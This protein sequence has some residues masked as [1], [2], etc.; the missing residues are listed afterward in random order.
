MS[1]FVLLRPWWLAILPPLALAAI[2]LARRGG[3]AGGWE[4]VIPG[5]TIAALRALGHLGGGRTAW[6]TLAPLLAAGVLAA[7]LAGPALPRRDAPVL[8]QSDA[9]VIAVDMSPSV[10]RGPG[11]ADAQAAAASVLAASAGRP[12]GLVLYDG[13]AYRASAPTEDRRSLETQIAVLGPETM[14]SAGS[15]PSAALGLAREMLAGVERADVVL[16]SD[17]GG[18]DEAATSEAGRLAGA[19]VTLSVLVLDGEAAGAPR[20]DA[21]ALR[22]LARAS[23]PARAP[24]PVLRRLGAVGPVSPDPAL[25]ALRYL[26]L[27]PFL[28]AFACL[29]MLAM[30]RR[31]A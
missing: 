2:W 16:I 20:S 24:E 31:R 25:T 7:G 27:G 23:A 1:G 15:R 13:E 17:G 4:D 29:P 6:T 28:A 18:V 21:A 10:A 19:G 11:L 26:D 5:R 22:A 14:P 12:V 8:A 3:D 9:V 30:F